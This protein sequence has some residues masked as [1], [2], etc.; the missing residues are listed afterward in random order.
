MRL[1]EANVCSLWCL[2]GYVW[3]EGVP[4][5]GC[6]LLKSQ[7]GA[8]PTVQVGRVNGSGFVFHLSK[9]DVMSATS[10]PTGRGSDRGAVERPAV[11]SDS[12]RRLST[13][14]KAASR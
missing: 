2:L 11:A 6:A 7:T 3:L 10:V 14:T 12:V 5:T 4:R 9:E 1:T 8:S 13:E